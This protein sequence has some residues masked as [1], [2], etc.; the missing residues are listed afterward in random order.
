MQLRSII[1]YLNI[2]APQKIAMAWDIS[3]LQIGNPDMEIS[4]IMLCLDVTGFVLDRV[5][6]TGA[7][8]IISHH[9]LIFNPVKNITNPL[10]LR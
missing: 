1:E 9:P 10:Y 3:G 2:L 5:L 8:L 7:N 4:S 6:Q